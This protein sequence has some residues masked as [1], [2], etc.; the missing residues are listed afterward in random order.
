MK[1]RV[2]EIDKAV[3]YLG[4]LS[5][6][7]TSKKEMFAWILA[8]VNLKLDGWKENLI[9]KARKEVPIKAVIQAIPQYAMSIFKIPHSISRSVK[10]M[11]AVFW[12]KNNTL[13][14]V[15]IGKDRNISK[16]ERKN[17]VGNALLARE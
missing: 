16:K 5:D 3:K 2:S 8:R 11:I 14:L 15:F 9:S 7:G 10:M 6:R 1:L 17:E 12:W 13:G 4:I